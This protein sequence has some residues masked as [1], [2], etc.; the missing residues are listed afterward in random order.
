MSNKK[1]HNAFAV[2]CHFVGKRNAWWYKIYAE[3]YFGKE[4]TFFV[5]NSKIKTYKFRRSVQPRSF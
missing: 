3:S 2:R 1:K 4:N 5:I